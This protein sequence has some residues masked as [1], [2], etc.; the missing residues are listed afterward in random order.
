[1]AAELRDLAVA[2]PAPEPGGVACSG[3]LATLVAI[4]LRSG[5]A[6]HVLLRMGS[7][8]ARRFDVFVRKAKRLKWAEVLRT[9]VPITVKATCRRSKLYHSG[10]V[11]QRVATAVAEALG[12]EPAGEGEPIQ[13]LARVVD[14]E[15]TLSVDTSGAALHRRGWRQQT[16]KAPLREDLARALLVR[17]GWTP[18][19]ALVDP[20]MG[21]GTILIE[22]ATMAMQ[23]APGLRRSFALERLALGAAATMESARASAREQVRERPLAALLGRDR[24]AGAVRAATGNAERAGV[25]EHLTLEQAD[26]REPWTI[27]GPV[28][29]CTNPPY[30]RRVDSGREITPTYRALGE[31]IRTHGPRAKVGIVMADRPLTRALG[32]SLRPGLT[33]D[34]GGIKVDFM[35]GS[36][37]GRE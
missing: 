32:L 37:K 6:N 34:H 15:C 12:V 25:L 11:E 18:E 1:M 23:I 13:L 4:N 30:G 21:S 3:D 26:V 17:A 14:D 2:E 27:D 28:V 31:A 29:V 9:D 16:G 8:T 19:A 24:T 7:F 10:A 33:T 35:V 22:A 20:M 5:L 36:V